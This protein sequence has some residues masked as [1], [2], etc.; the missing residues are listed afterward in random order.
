VYA[1]IRS[2]NGLRVFAQEEVIR[3]KN[4]I[5]RWFSIY[6]PNYK[7]VYGNISATSGLMI[8]KKAPLPEDIVKRKRSTLFE[9]H[10][11]TI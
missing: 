4:R 9:H 6:F 7:D 1:E 11:L 2:L 3:L 5:A 10:N 8:L